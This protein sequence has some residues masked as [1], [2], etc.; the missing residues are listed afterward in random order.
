VLAKWL[1]VEPRVLLLDEPT[2][3]VDAGAK[4]DILELVVTAAAGGV[5]VVV[6]SGDHEQLAAI[7]HRVVVLQ[8]GRA[9]HELAGDDATEEALIRASD[10]RGTNVAA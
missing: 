8:H 6:F 10:Y 7:C 5:A 2:Q 9:V 1:Q 3:G 4:R